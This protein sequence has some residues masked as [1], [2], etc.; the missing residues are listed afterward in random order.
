MSAPQWGATFER[1]GRAQH[2]DRAGSH[3]VEVTQGTIVVWPREGAVTAG[4]GTVPAFG[5]LEGS[6]TLGTEF[7]VRESTTVRSE[8][9]QGPSE[10]QGPQGDS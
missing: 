1:S 4:V 6:P 8:L 9:K 10:Q 3:F 7:R 5:Q 2:G